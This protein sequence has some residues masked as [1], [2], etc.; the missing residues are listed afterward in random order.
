MSSLHQTKSILQSHMPSRTRNFQIQTENMPEMILNQLIESLTDYGFFQVD[1]QG[2]IQSWND[3]AKKLFLYESEEIIGE[4]LN[5]LY[6]VDESLP[7]FSSPDYYPESLFE[8]WQIRRDRSRFWAQVKYSPLITLDGDFIGY[9]VIV[10]DLSESRQ[11]ERQKAEFIGTA[12]HELKTP[13][14]SIKGYTQIL[15][16]SCGTDPKSAV[17]LNKMNDQINRLGLLVDE[18][19]DVSKIQ[20]GKLILQPETVDVSSLV[21]DIAEDIQTISP[22]HEIIIQEDQPISIT[23]ADR[24][25]LSQV[26]VN[27]LTNAIKFSPKANTIFVK[28]ENDKDSIRVS[29]RDFGIG[30]SKKNVYHIFE[31]FYQVENTIRKSFSGLGLGLYISSEIIKQHGGKIWVESEKGKGSLFGFSVPIKKN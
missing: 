6:D 18:L 27:L 23:L 4:K 11:L 7:L 16:H 28:I 24:Y 19:L 21:R 31:R 8:G 22:S 9:L 1:D 17:F 30:I 26:L 13:V 5:H 15:Q 12:S 20:S 2:Y 14:A 29:V 3:G 25:R 10:K